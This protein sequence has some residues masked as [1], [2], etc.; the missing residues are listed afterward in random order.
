MALVWMLASMQM[1]TAISSY[2]LSPEV[3]M[4]IGKVFYGDYAPTQ[5]PVLDNHY[6]VTFLHRFVGFLFMAIVPLQFMPS[7]RARHIAFHRWSGRIL[8]ALG[9]IFGVSALI[10]AGRFPYAGA[11][12][13]IPMYFFGLIFIYSMVR[14]FFEVRR[15]NV[16]LHR[17]WISV[18][19][20]SVWALRRSAC[21]TLFVCTPRTGA[22]R[23]C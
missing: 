7:I 17:E 11:R 5:F 19:L 10:M 1:M 3:H 16:A 6:V 23:T 9:L 21:S 8:V 4:A 20:P 18:V 2:V 22:S 15:G 12:E 13:I 14:A